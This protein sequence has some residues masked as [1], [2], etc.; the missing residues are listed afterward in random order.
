MKE[1]SSFFETLLNRLAAARVVLLFFFH[2]VVFAGAYAFSYL[3]RFEFTIPPEYGLIFKS[4]LFIVVGFQLVIGFLFGFYRGWWRYVGIADVVR[5]VFGLTTATAVLV[6]LWYVGTKFGIE[7]RF[8]RT[9]RG[10]LLID[11]AFSLLALFG[12]RVLVRLGRDR[13]RAQEIPDGQ[14]RVLI[15][16]AGDAGETLVRELEHRPQIG[17]KVVGFV[18]DQRAKWGAQIRGIKV[19]GPIASIGTI[20][21]SLGADEALIAIPSA[22]GKRMRDIVRQLS[23]ADLQFKTIP[24]IDHLVT[25]KVHVSQLRPVN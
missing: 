22:S 10:V 16:G 4:S 19:M 23:E 2:A 24:G 12:A 7:E 14:K 17:L 3:L 9:P 13:F 1:D 20:A 5:L 15:V 6:A 21:D 25:G 8:V 11:W 18:D